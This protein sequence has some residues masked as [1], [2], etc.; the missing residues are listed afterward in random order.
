MQIFGKFKMP[1]DVVLSTKTFIISHLTILI[2]ALIYFAGLYYILYPERFKPAVIEYNAVTK[3]PVSLF[4]EITNPEDDIMVTD[5]N[6]IISGKTSPNASIII[7]NGE[8]DAGLQSDKNGEFSKVFSLNPGANI[9]EIDTYDTDGNSKTVI[10]EVYY[11]KEE[12]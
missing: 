4:L 5:P 7:S 6:L 10:K 8:N 11:S 2:M 12:L 3:E 1:K 9:I